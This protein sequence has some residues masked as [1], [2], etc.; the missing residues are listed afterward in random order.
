M[1]SHLKKGSKVAWS[2]E[3]GEVQGKVVERVMNDRRFAGKV[4]RASPEKPSYVV[5]SD[6][7][8]AL[9]MH[10]ASALRPITAKKKTVAKP[11]AP[12]ATKAHAKKTKSSPAKAGRV[13]GKK[14]AR[15]LN[16]RSKKVAS[17]KKNK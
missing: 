13:V 15:A 17:S 1:T 10:Q 2:F 8:G 4:R 9:A 7:T 11:A 5:Q 16:T 14:A 3:R 12:R 6:R